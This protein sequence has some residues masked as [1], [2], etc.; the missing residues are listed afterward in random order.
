MNTK[1]NYKR[2]IFV[3]FAFF[4]IIAFWQ[5]YDN[6][7]PKILTDKFGLPQ[8]ASGAIMAIDNIL[9]LF[10]LPLFGALSDRSKSRHGRRTPFIF[11]GTVAAVALLVLL[12]IPDRAQLKNLE[13]IDATEGAAYTEALETLWEANPAI[14]VEGEST[15]GKSFGEIVSSI[16]PFGGDTKKPLHDLIEKEKFLAITL[17]DPTGSTNPDYTAYVV[18][19]R[20]AYAASVTSAH[21]GPLVAFMVILFLALV[22]MGVFRSPAVALMPDVTV[23]PMR[24]KG[25]AVIN[26]MGAVGGVVVLLVGTVLG[27]GKITNALMPYTGFFV[28]VAVLMLASLAAFLFTVREPKWA[29]E[30][31]TESARLGIDTEEKVEKGERRLT[32]GERASL[33]LILFSVVFWYMGYNAVAS[34]YSVYASSVLNIDYNT[35]LLIA[36]AA[37]IVAYIPVGFLTSRF[38]R[39]KMV[40][41]GVLILGTAFVAASFMRVGSPVW[42]MN[43]LFTMAGIGWATI[44]VNSYPMVVELARG[45]DVGKY[46]G[47]YYTASMA[48]QVVTPVLSGVFMDIRFTTLFP[49]AA[50]FVALSFLTML[51]VRHG[52]STPTAG[53]TIASG[54]GGD[55]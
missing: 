47:Y 20:Q 23:K 44:N 26:L 2:T 32:R 40:L 30:M 29:A 35:T 15:D 14:R 46:T 54:L 37:A 21:P 13:K 9:A 6:I 50:I 16:N 55:D 45:G 34:K 51:F 22:A 18:P 38:G 4:L 1:L 12:S 33:L 31:E 28:I 3:G 25:N 42:L 17:Q 19:A 41:A 7:I 49:Y 39:K 11:V 10:L 8:A 52:D 5:A 36:N 48:A 53:E 27:T 43:L 24:S